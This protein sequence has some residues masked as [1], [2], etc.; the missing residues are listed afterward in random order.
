VMVVKAV[1][2]RMGRYARI[3][4]MVASVSMRG[5]DR[6]ERPVGSQNARYNEFGISRHKGSELNTWNRT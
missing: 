5:V 2:S 4:C 3:G 6:F 1:E